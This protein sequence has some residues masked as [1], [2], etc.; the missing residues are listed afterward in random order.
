M[1]S[2]ATEYLDELKLALRDAPFDLAHELYEGIAEELRTLSPSEVRVR[3]AELGAPSVI[4]AEILHEAREVGGAS[5]GAAGEVADRSGARSTWYIVLTALAVAIG[6]MVV[7]VLG[8]VVGIVLMWVSPVWGRLQKWLTTLAPMIAFAVVYLVVFVWQWATPKSESTSGFAPP[9]AENYEVLSPAMPGNFVGFGLNLP[10][11]ILV[12]M[13]G[14]F[15]SGVSLL[16][17]GL[18]RQKQLR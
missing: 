16:A 17:T 4:A 6:G 1:T 10:T 3:I 18:R 9:S 5:R 8:W 7:P 11:I 13:L 15:V 2:P 12:V 14:V